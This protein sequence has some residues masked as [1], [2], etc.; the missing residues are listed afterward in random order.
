MY[1]FLIFFVVLVGLYALVQVTDPK[2]AF[3]GQVPL[4]T[5]SN[6]IIPTKWIPTPVTLSPGTSDGVMPSLLPGPL[7]SGPYEQIA[8]NSPYPYQQPSLLRTTRARILSTLELLQGFLAFQAQEIENNSDPSIQLPLQTARS[9]FAR[10]NSE[11]AVLQRNPGLQSSLTEL[12]MAEINDNVAYLQREVELIG[13]N[14]PFQSPV[15]DLDLEGFQGQP[16]A[17]E[18][19]QNQ[20]Q[21]TDDVSTL[22]EPATEQQLQDFSG[23]VQGEVMR[24]SSSGTTDP[25]IVA[26]VGNLTRM[27][28]DVDGVLEK[29]QTGALLPLEVPIMGAD[30]DKALPVLSDT[31][32]PLPQILRTLQ[33]PAGLANMLPASMQNPQTGTL[34]QKYAQDFLDGASASISFNVNY[35]SPKATAQQG[36]QSRKST[37]TDTGF[38]SPLDLDNVAEDS[39]LTDMDAPDAVTDVYAQDPRAEGRAPITQGVEGRVPITQGVEGRAP[40]TQGSDPSRFPIPQ[41]GNLVLGAAGQFDWKARALQITQQI[42]KRGLDPN[43]FGAK[44]ERELAAM[45]VNQL[46]TFSW[47]GYTRMICTRLQAVDMNRT[48]EM[49]GCPPSTWK[50][51]ND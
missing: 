37:L 3:V 12:D 18:G 44:N 34:L 45:P 51:W 43:D 33:L 9:D 31:S 28:N 25:V 19:F 8:K 21:Q 35:A 29:V 26:R 32:Q 40:I 30:L 4:N 13:V 15:H 36:Q 46:N 11:A 47:K 1:A 49:C 22:Q 41:R 2:E 39:S 24:L 5:E 6:V 7:P 50:G 10:L 16:R 42:R 17:R 38:P 23:R 48:D 14:R 27:K 20:N